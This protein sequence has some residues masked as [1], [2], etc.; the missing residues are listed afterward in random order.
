MKWIEKAD[1]LCDINSAKCNLYDQNGNPLIWDN[2]HL[3]TRAY[4]G[5]GSFLYNHIGSARR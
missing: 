2:A 1:F 5:Y 3:T 4:P